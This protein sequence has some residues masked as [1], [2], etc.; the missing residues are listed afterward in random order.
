MN[1][2]LPLVSSKPKTTRSI[3]RPLCALLLY[4]K[5]AK[6]VKS[7]FLL[8]VVNSEKS[9][10]FIKKNQTNKPV[11]ILILALLKSLKTDKERKLKFA[12]PFENAKTF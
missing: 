7:E 4:P 8:L 11:C 12:H 9:L 10:G 2:N 5:T 6:V 1:Q 3:T